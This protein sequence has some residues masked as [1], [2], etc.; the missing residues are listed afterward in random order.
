MLNTVVGFSSSGDFA[1]VRSV[2]NTYQVIQQNIEFSP[3]SYRYIETYLAADGT[4][5]E[6]VYFS[7]NSV[8][9]SCTKTEPTRG[10]VAP[11]SVSLYD[12]VHFSSL[13]ADRCRIFLILGK[14]DDDYMHALIVPDDDRAPELKTM[15]LTW[16]EARAILDRKWK[17]KY[18]S[19]RLDSDMNQ[20]MDI[21]K[22]LSFEHF[23]ASRS[24]EI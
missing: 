9:L 19:V 7:A 23:S 6:L 17:D 16:A 4:F 2:R 21:I 11:K 10:D 3:T 18:A 12:L 20:D 5:Y 24:T 8:A 15:P 13:Y 14:T 1:Y 22:G